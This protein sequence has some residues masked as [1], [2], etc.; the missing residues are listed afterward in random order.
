MTE[1]EEEDRDR[2]LDGVLNTLLYFLVPILILVS[3]ALLWVALNTQAEIRDNHQQRVDIA[4]ER[5]LRLMS[6]LDSLAD[7]LE[8]VIRTPVGERAMT[9]ERARRIDLKTDLILEHLG[10]EFEEE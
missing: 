5:E 1:Q 9:H 10:I 8:D 3:G 4:R 6:R 2:K 7:D